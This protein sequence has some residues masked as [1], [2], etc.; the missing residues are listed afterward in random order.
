MKVKIILLLIFVAF[1]FNFACRDINTVEP[2]VDP[3][4]R[5]QGIFI[6][7]SSERPIGID[8]LFINE[9]DTL[10]LVASSVLP[11]RPDFTWNSGNEN[12]LKIM[13]SP[14]SQAIAFAIA[15]GLEGTATNFVLEDSTNVAKKT[16]PV[17]VMKHWADPLYFFYMGELNG[18]HYYMSLYKMLWTQSR[19]VCEK[20]GGHLVTINSAD[21]S[22]FLI[23]N[24]HPFIENNWI[25]LTFLFGNRRLNSWITGESLTYQ[26][27]T[28]SKPTEPGI[29]AENYFFMRG[30]GKW[31]KWHE[32]NYHYILEME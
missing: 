25:G 23:D 31:A 4:D 14:D 28:G 8:T 20:A 27:F 18:H 9:G 19:D 1:I 26:N 13:V 5:G 24:R 17:K 2:K 30:D 21:E 22:N 7:M 10:E 6:N 11:G 12:V 15:M 32:I 3:E 29:F 16:I